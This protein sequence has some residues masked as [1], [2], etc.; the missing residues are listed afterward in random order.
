MALSGSTPSQNIRPELEARTALSHD[1]FEKLGS[2]IYETCG[3]KM[4]QT[5][6]TMLEARL[7]KRIRALGFASF[8]EY[9]GFLFSP[10]GKSNELVHMIDA[11]TTNK[12]DFFRVP[13]SRHPQDTDGL[14]CSV[15]FR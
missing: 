12:T 13:R 10:D 3:I 7:L 14:V 6:K 1:L 9:C 15:L 11:V 8:G 2:F 4:P 5:K